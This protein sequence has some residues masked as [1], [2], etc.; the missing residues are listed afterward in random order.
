ME[1]K[2]L[3]Q[4]ST[5]IVKLGHFDG[6]SFKRWQKKMHFLLATLNG[7]YVLNKPY[8][9]ESENKTLAESRDRL[10]FRIDDFICRGHI[11]NAMSDPLFDLYENY[12]TARDL[13]KAL[14]ERYLMEDATSKIFIVSK[15]NSYKMVDSRPIMD[16][17]Y[18][19]EHILSMFTQ[20]N[21]NMDES[22]QVASIIDKLPSTWKDVK[23]NLKHHKDDLSL[24]DLGKHLLIEEQYCLENKANDDTSKVHLV[25][26]KGE[27]S[28]IDEKINGDSSVLQGYTY[29]SWITR[30]DYAS[31]SGWIYTLGGGV[32]SW[33]SNIQSWVTNFTMIAEF[34][35]MASCY[36]ET[37]WLWDLSM[38][39]PLWPEPISLCIV[40]VNLHYQECKILY[41]ERKIPLALP[42]ERGPAIGLWCK[43]NVAGAWVTRRGSPNYPVGNRVV[44]VRSS[45]VI[46]SPFCSVVTGD[47][48]SWNGTRLRPR[49]RSL[50]NY[51]AHAL[52]YCMWTMLLTELRS[53]C[54]LQNCGVHAPC[55][56]VQVML[57]AE[58]LAFD[59]T[60]LR[61]AQLLAV[62]GLVCVPHTLLGARIVA[63]VHLS[64]FPPFDEGSI[65][66]VTSVLTQRELDHHCSVF[67]IPANLRPELHDRN[68]IIK[69]SLEGKIGMYTCFIEF[70]NFRI[71]LSK[72]LLCILEYY[73]INLSQLSV[74][75]AS[76]VSHFEI[77]CRALGRVP[78]V[79]TFRRLYVNSISNGWLSFSKR[80]GVDEPCCYSK[81]FDSLKNWNNRFFWID[82]SVCLLAIPWFSGTFIVKDQLL[83]DEAVDLPCVEL[84]NN[85]RTIIRKYPKVFLCLV[86]L[87][88][89]FTKSDVRPTLLHSND[90]EMG[91]LDFVNSANPF[92]VNTGELT[93]AENEAPLLAETKDKVI[94][95]SP[96]TTSLVDHSIQDELDVNVGKRKKRVAFVSGSPPVKKAR[97][98]GITISDYRSNIPAKSPSALRRLI[99]Q[100]GQA[101][102]GSGSVVPAAGDATSSS[103]T[104]TLER[105]LEDDIRD[106]GDAGFL[107][108]FNINSTQHIC[109]AYELRLRYEHEII[110]KEKFERKFT[111][112]VL[113]VQQ[114]DAEIADLKSEEVVDLNGKNSELLGKVS[115]LESTHGELSAQVAKLMTDCEVLRSEVTGEA[116]LREEFKSFQDVEARR[117]KQR[118]A[119]L[120]ARIADV[121]RDMDNDLYPHMFTAI[122]G[123]RFV[124][125]KVISFAINKGIQEGLEA[126]IEHGKSRRTLAQVEAYNPRVKDEFV[127]AVTNFKNVS[128]TLLDVLDSLKDSLL[129]SIIHHSYLS[130]SGSVSGEMLLSEVVPTAR[131][132]A[133]RRGLC[134][135]PLGGTS[136]SAPP[137]GSSL[138][139]AD[140]QVSTL[141][142]SG[143]GGSAT[144]PPVV[145]AHDDLFDTS[146]LD[147][148][149]GT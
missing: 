3:M 22:I 47:R 91:L 42:W 143:D 132:A 18:E 108:A 129:T 133:K 99:R 45:S 139:V 33:G 124:L 19:L 141:V 14:E 123:R 85:N 27:S 63:T 71:P 81:K 62:S 120:D 72:F 10:K 90:E 145:R 67:N 11:L 50:R 100:S 82:A 34:V 48:L 4:M 126:G 46:P 119:E 56:H 40:I 75:G 137:H 41:I 105:S 64:L 147:G 8:P 94:S 114:R 111:D 93:L 51:R 117:F 57:L 16:Q 32:V 55:G 5:D 89:S 59:I 70:A 77:M 138:G 23:K 106:N 13:W 60:R 7:V 88:R 142:L 149:G 52:C 144:Q 54:S 61:S 36:K 20:N 69:D 30:E 96:Q 118:S 58:R 9:E 49:L 76:K 130:E 110:T 115:S 1:S 31:M 25:E 44:A 74:I 6:G 73:Q 128:F 97:T 53:S 79:G 148:A 116:K 2:N 86:D 134:P 135:P 65:Y 112:S 107:D 26:E 21:M 140:Y 80:G 104:P 39:I 146:V 78:I 17:M 35:A 12:P 121:R 29:A 38:N 109:M 95:P 37:E 87:T 83:V 92:K 68:A 24:K 136:S 101:K 43:S 131:V 98:E 125:G 122:A 28:K 113:I 102:S 103:V 66:T 84:L 127:S 15:F